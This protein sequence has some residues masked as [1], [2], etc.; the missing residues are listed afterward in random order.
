MQNGSMSLLFMNYSD[1]DTK[2]NIIAYKDEL[3]ERFRDLNIAWL[4]KYFYVEPIDDEML[5][6]P[7]QYIIEKGGHIYFAEWN[8]TIAG[9]FALMPLD[10]GIYELGKMAVDEQFHGKR[11]GHSMLEFCIHRAIELKAR[12]VILYSNTK[13]KPAIHLYRKFGFIEIPLGDTI[14]KR[15]DIKM[16]C[17][18]FYEQ[19]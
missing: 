14:Y 17:K 7:R 9:T 18:L 15:S 1:M 16:E 5:S 8:G 19:D 3:A 11:I 13:L 12:K 6:Q 2:V 10:D 4:Q